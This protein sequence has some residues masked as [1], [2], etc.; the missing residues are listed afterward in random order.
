[1]V[2]SGISATKISNPVARPLGLLLSFWHSGQRVHRFLWCLLHIFVFR[3]YFGGYLMIKKEEK[4]AF[5][6]SFTLYIHYTLF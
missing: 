4:R 5:T 1:M 3:R 2:I 6:R